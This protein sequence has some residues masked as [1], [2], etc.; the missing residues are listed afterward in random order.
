MNNPAGYDLDSEIPLARFPAFWALPF[1][2]LNS[3]LSVGPQV[4]QP[5]ERVDLKP[6]THL[7]NCG[8]APFFICT[9]TKL[10]SEG[11]FAEAEGEPGVGSDRDMALGTLKSV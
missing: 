11:G 3:F 6:T 1:T 5:R 10:Q 7:L 8:P 4:I 2:G 9:G